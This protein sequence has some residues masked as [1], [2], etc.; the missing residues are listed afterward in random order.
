MKIIAT[1][2]L[3][4]FFILIFNRITLAQGPIYLDSSAS[5]NDRVEDLL[6]RMTLDEKI[7]QMMQVDCKGLYGS[8][9]DIANYYIGSVL[10]GGSSDPPNSDNSTTS[11]ANLYDSLQSYALKTRL[12]IPLIYGIDAVHGN[13][14][15]Y[16]ATIFPHNIGLGCTR[17]SVLVERAAEITASEVAATGINWTFGPCIAVP[18]D[19]RWGRTYEGFGETPEL[20]EM[21]GAAEVRGFQGD[22]LS[23]QLSILA[24][25]KH[26]LGDGGTLN[27]VDQGNTVANEETIRNI[28]L[29]GYIAAI[30]A[31]VG[32]IMVSYSSINGQKMHGSKYWI[33]DVLKNEIAFKGFVVS[34]WGGIDQLGSDYKQN[35]ETAI[36]A[37]I[38]MIMLPFR[39]KEFFTDMKSLVEEGKIDTNRINDAAYRILKKKFEL[40]LFENPYSNRNLIAS[41][42]SDAHRNVARQCVR[43][44]LVLLK[45]VNNVLPIPKINARIIVA[46]DHADN[47]GYQCGGWTIDWQGKGGDITFGT[48]ILDGMKKAAPLDQ[49]DFSQIGKFSD[50]NADY[51]IVVIGE[52]PYAE[53]YGDTDNLNISSPDVDLI[54]KMKSYGN[55]VVVILISGRPLIIDKFLPY[56]DAV[57]AAWLPGTE[58]EGISD[59]LF[60]DYEPKGILSHSWPSSMSQ[61]PINY[62]D[63]NY[64]PLFSYGYG[65]TS[66]EDSIN[67]SIHGNDQIPGKYQLYQNYPNPFNPST[68]IRYTIQDENNNMSSVQTTLKVY[69][70]LGNV[71]ATLV[72]KLQ[73]PGNYEIEFSASNLSSGIY[74]YQLRAGTFIQTK[75]MI[76][77]K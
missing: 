57:V 4:I 66:F 30:N 53:G 56:S 52:K 21:M 77:L 48:T 59:V 20:A 45:R 39:Y 49:I 76:L 18:R 38:D 28:H 29:P 65:I 11:W 44:S 72:N 6:S 40:G 67:V 22:T 27:G 35:V 17:D 55:P 24:C 42:G 26:F 62:G 33:T 54:K 15:I 36:N 37:G 58:G 2:F 14:N 43:E 8:Y 73:Q 10:S 32:S 63:E 61:I 9:P 3:Y 51:S 68:V 47:L 41:V 64:E 16:G 13:N 19:D 7:G 69:D 34:D 50:T 60:G 74:F 23:G 1:S 70:F 31:G 71:V 12:K 46:G 75:K 5:V 25:A